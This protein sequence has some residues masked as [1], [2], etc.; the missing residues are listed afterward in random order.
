MNILTLVC[1]RRTCVPPGNR[2]WRDTAV[3]RLPRLVHWDRRGVRRA[4][5]TDDSAD[6]VLGQRAPHR[7]DFTWGTMMSVPHHSV[8]ITK[9]MGPSTQLFH[10][11]RL[12]TFCLNSFLIMLRV[13]LLFYVGF[14][15]L[16]A[17]TVAGIGRCS[18]ILTLNLKMSLS[19]PVIQQPFLRLLWVSL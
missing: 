14:W 15:K 5:C 16:N 9:N 6:K 4:P 8:L 13:L 19:S 11:H 18:L 7:W 3:R 17:P 1:C 10:P 2:G 12:C